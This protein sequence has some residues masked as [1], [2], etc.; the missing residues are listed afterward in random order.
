MIRECDRRAQRVKDVGLTFIR[1]EIQRRDVEEQTERMV[2][3]MAEVRSL[4][5][6]ITAFTVINTVAVI[7]AL[8][9]GC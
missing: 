3:M 9:L 8:W 7:L 5:R 6:W 2:R 1:D 4:T